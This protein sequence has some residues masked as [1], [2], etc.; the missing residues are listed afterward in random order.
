[1]QLAASMAAAIVVIPMLEYE[2]SPTLLALVFSAFSTM[3]N[4]CNLWW[5]REESSA[6]N[7]EQ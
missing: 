4:R 1:M 7:E 5:N 2:Y 3:A 6:A